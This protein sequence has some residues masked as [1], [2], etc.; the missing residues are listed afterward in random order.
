MKEI[1]IKVRVESA[2][3]I[4]EQ[5]KSRG[6]LFS[7]PVSQ[8]D[9]IFIPLDEPTVPVSLGVN[10]LRIRRQDDKNLFTLKQGQELAKIERELEVADPET[11]EEI[12]LMLGYKKIV[13]ISKNRSKCK[14]GELEICV[15][16]VFGL[17][18]FVEV[19][20]ITAED[21]ETVQAE[22]LSFLAG[23][24]VDVSR[25]EKVGY[26]ILFVQKYGNG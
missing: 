5:L 26:D 1:E 22:L 16:E 9:D 15:D 7:S 17:G 11:L 4:I 20:K 18:D 24:G 13:Q 19:E 21:P 12:I 8:R 3:K 10:V 2:G 25:R 14:M 23:L 6:C